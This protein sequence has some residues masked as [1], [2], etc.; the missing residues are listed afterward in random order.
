M[1]TMASIAGQGTAGS[2]AIAFGLAVGAAAALIAPGTSRAQGFSAVV[3]PPRIEVALQPGK[4]TRQVIE[5]TH[6]A[7]QRGNYRV[8][9]NDWVLSADGN[10]A[11]FSDEL[12]PNSCRPWVVLESRDLALAPNGKTRF[13][14]DITPPPDAVAA[15][16]RFAIMVEGTEQVVKTEGP[17]SFPVSGRIGVIVYAAVGDARPQLDISQAPATI[18]DGITLPQVQVRN[19]GNAHGRLGGFLV[20]TDP[21]GRQIDFV[22]ESLPIL[23]GQSRLIPL[24]PNVPGTET[25]KPEYP[26]AVKGNIEWGNQKSAIDFRYDGVVPN[27]GPPAKAPSP[28][29]RNPPGKQAPENSPLVPRPAAK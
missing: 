24:I 5:I 14:F 17:V 15:E 25:F 26:L 29:A 1:S 8:Y 23:P 6:V 13:R 28:A 10:S 3:S 19:T 20:A 4:S 11:V 12:A 9:T 22:P 7:S 2:F 21:T 16:C 27:S 18:R